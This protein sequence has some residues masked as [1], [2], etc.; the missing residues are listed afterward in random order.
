[1]KHKFGTPPTF[2]NEFAIKIYKQIE[3]EAGDVTRFRLNE[4][5][6]S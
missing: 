5:L 6:E 3:D 4:I 1:M 2:T